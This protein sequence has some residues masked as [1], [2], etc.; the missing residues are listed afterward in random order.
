MQK[1][2]QNRRS[3][4]Q[5]LTNMIS[6]VLEFRFAC[7]TAAKFVSQA[8]LPPKIRMHVA[9]RGTAAMSYMCKQN[10]TKIKN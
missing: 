9:L 1:N 5:Q 6:Y 2:S 8:A 4:I 10:V 7:G 3:Q